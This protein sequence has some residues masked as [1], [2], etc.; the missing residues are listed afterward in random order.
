MNK[1]L[2][3]SAAA[4]VLL[5]SGCTSP[6]GPAEVTPAPVLDRADG[7]EYT[8][9]AA[10]SVASDCTGTVVDTGVDTAP[11]YVLTNGHCLGMDGQD[12]NE[13]LLDDDGYG[14]A[15]FFAFHDVP[16]NDRV[17]VPVER[18]E[19]A[20]M[21]SADIGVL[22]LD[23]TLGELKDRGIK[24]LPLDPSAATNGTRVANIA[25]PVTD[26]EIQDWALRKGSCTLSEKTDLIEFRWFW[27]GEIANN[28][29]GVLGGSSGSPLIT[30]G[31]VVSMINTTS[32]GVSAE[33]G[34]ACYLGQPCQVR[35]DRVKF[36]QDTAYGVDLTGVESCFV[37][38][39]F[40]TGGNCPLPVAVTPGVF[41]GGT[42]SADGTDT[43]DEPATISLTPPVGD[44]TYLVKTG[45]HS[46]AACRDNGFFADAEQF[47]VAAE[48]TEVVDV[49]LPAK[50]S[51]QF[52]CVKA[53]EDDPAVLIFNV[54]TTAPAK[55]PELSVTRFDDGAVSIDPLFDN[56]EIVDIQ[57]LT[58]PADSTNCADRDLYTQYFRQPLMAQSNE[59]PLRVCSVGFDLAG[60]ESPVSD[61]VVAAE[62]D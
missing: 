53:G 49:S 26:L 25:F 10:L 28:C 27:R 6:S 34:K 47:A 23:A 32:G 21:Y 17:V 1:I 14:E 31:A 24:P 62:A 42:F 58:G 16:E 59:L 35:G 52:A 36:V 56:P 2:A 20:T 37:N 61:E 51:F 11:A 33:Q 48:Q 29:P 4:L 15:T 46:P 40:S 57:W 19:Y 8:G 39:T 3:A 50:E 38:G 43:A 9:V 12:P 60:N 45:L 13:V 41:G 18:F 22:R 30:D 5:S 7:D 44:L 54:D 55:G